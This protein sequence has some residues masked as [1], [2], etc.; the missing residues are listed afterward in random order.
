MALTRVVRTDRSQAKTT[1]TKTKPSRHHVAT[2]AAHTGLRLAMSFL[3]IT[4]IITMKENKKLT[5][6]FPI[7]IPIIYYH[8]VLNI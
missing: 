1:C 3:K 6:A 8:T 2:C 7:S 4:Y 5:Q